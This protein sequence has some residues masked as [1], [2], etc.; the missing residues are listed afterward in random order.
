L[1][2]DATGTIESPELPMTTSAVS[3]VTLC[4]TRALAATLQQHPAKISS[5]QKEVHLETCVL[6]CLS[7]LGH[8]RHE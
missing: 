2:F 3:S 5:S 4:S 1:E 6:P 8:K 7:N